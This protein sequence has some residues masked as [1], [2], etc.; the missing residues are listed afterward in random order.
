M[1]IAGGKPSVPLL[2]SVTLSGVM[3]INLYAPS[4]PDIAREFATTG[5]NVQLTV[6]VFLVAFAVAQL[7]YGPVSDRYGRR[8][9]LLG[10][11]AIFIAANVIC[12]A[13]FSIEYLMAARVFQAIGACGGSVLTRAIVRDA[14]GREDSVRVMGYLAMGTGVAAAIAPSIGGLIQA[15]VGWRGGFVFL[16]VL[17]GIPIVLV[18]RV[19]EETHLD[20]AAH[21]GGGRRWISN[22]GTLLRSPTFLGY[23]LSVAFVNGGFF[24]F[25][26]AAPFILVD[27]LGQAPEKVGLFLLYSTGGF[28]IGSLIGP[29][30]V[31]RIGLDTVIVGGAISIFLAVAVMAVIGLNGHLSTNT[32]MVPMFVVGISS[33]FVFPPAAAAAVGVVPGISGTASGLMGFTQLGMG[34]VGTGFASLFVHDTQ[35]PLAFIMLGMA[36]G[37]LASLWLI[38]RGRRLP[39]RG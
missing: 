17:A 23:T 28:L 29:R 7:I 5:S 39:P 38:S 1:L 34:A 2:L 13:A 20:R 4:M 8:P 19:L 6:L 16:A 18:W 9:V 36:A 14:Y 22:F 30:I 27:G 33:G 35:V 21:V 15:T 37:G 3:A 31:R 24:T 12:A 25:I 32:V 11:L 26:A 10:G